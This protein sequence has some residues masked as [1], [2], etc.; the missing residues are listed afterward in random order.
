MSPLI[1]SSFLFAALPALA[2]LLTIDRIYSDPALSG[3]RVRGLQV[4][5]DGARVTVLKGRP[6]SSS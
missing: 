6:D 4:A 5:T 3:P 2:E 1:F